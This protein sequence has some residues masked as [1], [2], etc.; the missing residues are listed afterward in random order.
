MTLGS[1]YLPRASLS[2]AK[3]LPR[4]INFTSLKVNNILFR[5]FVLKKGRKNPNL[6]ERKIF[7]SRKASFRPASQLSVT[8]SC[9]DFSLH[10]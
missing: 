5:F 3:I 8:K 9:W 2:G 7:L 6:R 10:S 4:V 1:N